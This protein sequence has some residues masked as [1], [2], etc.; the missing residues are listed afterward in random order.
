MGSVGYS[1]CKILGIDASLITD[2]LLETH[3]DGRTCLVITRFLSPEE[4]DRLEVL[5]ET[6]N[7]TD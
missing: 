1:L 4:I 5:S 7:R 2:L 3:V 6:E